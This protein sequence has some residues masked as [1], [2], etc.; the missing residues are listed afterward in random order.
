[1]EILT[2]IARLGK[3]QKET[4]CRIIS[5]GWRSPKGEASYDERARLVAELVLTAILN[6][7]GGAASHAGNGDI[8]AR[9][10]R[11]AKK[12]QDISR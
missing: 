5:T 1:M 7:R 3:Q 4:A 11:C 12:G 10:L 6:L 8:W 2:E 9:A